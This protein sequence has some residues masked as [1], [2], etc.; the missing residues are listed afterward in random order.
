MTAVEEDSVPGLGIVGGATELN[1][2]AVVEGS[3]LSLVAPMEETSKLGLGAMG[4]ATGLG[5]AAV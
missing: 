1:L 3:E 4:G 2:P 5:F